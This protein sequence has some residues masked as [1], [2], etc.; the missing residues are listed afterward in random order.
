MLYRLSPRHPLDSHYY[1]IHSRCYL[2]S[3]IV[4]TVPCQ[5][6]RY[7]TKRIYKN[8][9]NKLRKTKSKIR[10]KNQSGSIFG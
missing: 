3:Y 7:F 4:C 9:R 10:I 8:N 6:P 5:S 1:L 2:R